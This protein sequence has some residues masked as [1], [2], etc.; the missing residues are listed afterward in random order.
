MKHILLTLAGSCGRVAKQRPP[1]DGG[2]L[3]SAALHGAQLPPG[4]GI[5]GIVP[6]AP[7]W[8]PTVSGRAPSRVRC[9]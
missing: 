4:T 6:M 8:P 7:H 2:V 1:V 9:M 5:Q 3:V